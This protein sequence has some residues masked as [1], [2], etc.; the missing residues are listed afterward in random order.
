MRKIL[1]NLCLVALLLISFTS[2]LVSNEPYE[3]K[4]TDGEG[5]SPSPT[6]LCS[7][8]IE[9]GKREYY[10]GEDFDS[11]TI[12]VTLTGELDERILTE[13]EFDLDFSDFN[14]AVSGEYTITVYYKADREIK[15]EY[16]VTVNEAPEIRDEEKDSVWGKDLWL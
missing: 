16:T 1:T 7:L 8:E 2:C 5:E 9:G 11:E 6:V 4:S 14:K 3:S 12:V 15:A 13:E 10:I